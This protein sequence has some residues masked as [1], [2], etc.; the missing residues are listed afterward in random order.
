MLTS[1]WGVPH[2]ALHKG[3]NRCQSIAAIKMLTAAEMKLMCVC[4]PLLG[5]ICTAT[6]PKRKFPSTSETLAS[7]YQLTSVRWNTWADYNLCSFVPAC[8]L[9]GGR[10]LRGPGGPGCWGWTDWHTVTGKGCSPLR[11]RHTHTRNGST[12]TDLKS[13][14]TSTTY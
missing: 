12:N 7:F 4:M 3:L 5:F 1:C 6:G 2:T 9:H 13:S 14:A 10:S 8:R 11:R